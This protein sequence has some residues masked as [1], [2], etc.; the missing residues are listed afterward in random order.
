MNLPGDVLNLEFG[1]RDFNRLL[2][3]QSREVM[4]SRDLKKQYE[5]LKHVVCG[6]NNISKFNKITSLRFNKSCMIL[7]MLCNLFMYSLLMLFNCTF[8]EYFNFIVLKKRLILIFFIYLCHIY[9]FCINNFK[10]ILGVKT[11]TNV[12]IMCK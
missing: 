10:H 9:H 4:P 8:N 12:H 7:L 1:D 11:L 3:S 5:Q 6:K 2:A